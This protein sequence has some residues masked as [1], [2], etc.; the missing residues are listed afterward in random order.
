MGAIRWLL[1]VGCFPLV[2]APAAC[3]EQRAGTPEFRRHILPILSKAGCNS[4]ACHG[5]LAGKGGF[6]LSLRGYD[7]LADHFTI[8]RQAHGRRVELA[9]PGRSL[10]LAKP[11]G[12]LPHKGG[13]RLDPQSEDYRKIATW[14]TDGA[15][16]PRDDDPAL[17]RIEVTPQ[18]A[19][20]MPGQQQALTVRAFYSDGREEDVTQWARFS[21]ANQTVARVD[22][23]GEVTVL[24]PGEGAIV[25]WFSS[26][27]DLARMTSPFDNQIEASVFAAAP[28]RNF[29]DELNL[30]KL[31]SLRLHPSPRCTDEQFLRRVF[32]DAIGTLPTSQEVIAFVAD[33]DPAKR[34]RWIDQLLARPE[35]VDYW[36]YRWSDVLLVNGRRL[37]PKA[38]EAYYRWVR[39]H[40]RDNTAWNQVVREIVTATGSSYENGATNFYALHQSPEEMTENV[41][42]AFL[43]LSIGCAKCH[44][45]PLEKWTN[46]QY[47]AMAN[48]FARVRAK[49]WGGDGRSGDGLRTLF[50][51]DRGDL[52]QPSSGRPQPPT[53]LDGTPIPLDSTEDRR[54]HLADW[55]TSASNPYFARA[56]TNRIWAAFFGVGLVESV[57]DLRLSNPASDERLLRAA[58]DYLTQHEFDLKQLMRVIMQSET[59]Q[60]SSLVLPENRADRRY[61]SRYFPRRLPAEVLLD[62]IAQV[63]GV[64]SQFTQIGYD[65]A[66]FQKTAAYPRGTR[67]IQLQDSAVVSNFLKTFGRNERDITCE[68][69]RSNTP[70]MVQVLHINNGVTINDRLRDKDS[71]IAQAMSE[72][73][74][75]QTIRQAYLRTLSRQPTDNERTRLA[76]LIT[77]ADHEDRRELYED[78]FW[79]IMSSREFLFNH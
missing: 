76:A 63:S 42:Q 58:A 31:E 55:L 33:S 79:S 43:G 73:D 65:G 50:L 29:I 11:T 77:A 8:T 23:D 70:S 21:S 19:M 16:G 62:A 61:Y 39:Q 78:L 51:A 22:D 56:V 10:L 49:G 38:V 45:H 5:A 12:A 69:E 57:D 41:S 60:R 34:D 44:N 2:S 26:Q 52:I 68:C 59:Y 14:L 20:L 54:V 71:C 46:D 30:Q 48:L 36:T 53:P 72:P 64:P 6:K 32:L 18:Q 74:V 47:Y 17:L 1:V 37:R 13:L 67:A 25:A 9:D 7:P 3:A 15:P 66:D 40:V 24:G 28:R 4:G 27:I 35:F 75:H